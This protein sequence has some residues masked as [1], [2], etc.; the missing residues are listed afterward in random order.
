LPDVS[1]NG[2]LKIAGVTKVRYFPHAEKQAVEA[3]NE[4]KGLFGR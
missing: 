4:L 1:E 3:M 2:A